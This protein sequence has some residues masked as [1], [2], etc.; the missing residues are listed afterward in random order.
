MSV[1][2]NPLDQNVFATGSTDATVRLWDLRTNKCIQTFRAHSS[3]VNVLCHCIKKLASLSSVFIYVVILLIC[4]IY[5][6]P[7]KIIDKNSVRYFPSGSCIASGSDDST[8]RLWDVGSRRQI[9]QYDDLKNKVG[10]VVADL[11]FTKS[12]STLFAAYDEEP[13]CVAWNTLAAEKEFSLE[14]PIRA[15][16]LRVHPAGEEFIKTKGREKQ[17]FFKKTLLDGKQSTV[18]YL[19]FC[20]YYIDCFFKL[21]KKLRDIIFVS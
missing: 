8:I 17:E 4:E 21:W 7:K 13:F 5:P 9:N 18:L 1:D 12:G 14:H 11:D 6:N 10:S 15:P 3:D 2:L 19:V 20:Y 16:C